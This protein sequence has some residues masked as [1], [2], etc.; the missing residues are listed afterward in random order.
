[1]PSSTYPLR[2]QLRQLIYQALMETATL[3]RGRSPQENATEA[4]LRHLIVGR[5]RPDLHGRA[6][7]R[8]IELQLRTHA[9]GGEREKDAH[10]LT[11]VAD[12]HVSRHPSVPRASITWFAASSLSAARYL[13]TVFQPSQPR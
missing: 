4:S 12:P 9:G 8:Q 1:V 10:D 6:V 5:R 7:V 2:S 11:P 13:V 3:P